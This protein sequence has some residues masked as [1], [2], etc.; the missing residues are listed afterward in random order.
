MAS[1]CCF[2]VIYIIAVSCFSASFL[3][4]QPNEA[5]ILMNS[6]TN[7]IDRTRVYTGGR[8][9]VGM[10]KKFIVFPLYATTLDLPPLSI[11]TGASELS[12]GQTGS[13]GQTLTINISIQYRLQ[14]T[15]EGGEIVE[16]YND[17]NGNIARLTSAI[18][19]ISQAEVQ[20]ICSKIPPEAFFGQKTSFDMD[21]GSRDSV[22][23]AIVKGLRSALNVTRVNIEN[24]F[25]KE[26][27]FANAN[28]ISAV[29]NVV[30]SRQKTITQSVIAEQQSLTVNQ[31]SFRVQAEAYVAKVIASANGYASETTAKATGESFTMVTNAQQT[32]FAKIAGNLGL[33]PSQL[34]Q[35]LYLQSLKAKALTSKFVAGFGAPG[36]LLHDYVVANS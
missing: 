21:G 24:V 14:N 29:E 11:T 27:D 26:I 9:Y 15:A 4:L 31:D 5:G 32:A 33:N 8:Y 17:Y 23:L 19:S 18:V 2:V 20:K 16:I 22:D 13:S 28:Y 35:Y 25:V 34:L 3:T 6:I 7:T 12:G 1:I 36:G 30:V 10:F